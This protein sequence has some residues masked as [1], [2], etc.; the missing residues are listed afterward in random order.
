MVHDRTDEYVSIMRRARSACQGP[1][2]SDAH[3]G[4]KG[5]TKAGGLRKRWKAEGEVKPKMK[6][7][8]TSASELRCLFGGAKIFWRGFRLSAQ[9]VH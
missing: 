7:E 6:L 3:V 9:E 2:R 5:G 8:Q 4:G 1:G